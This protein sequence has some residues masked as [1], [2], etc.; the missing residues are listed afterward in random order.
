MRSWLEL[1]RESLLHNLRGVKA[2]VGQSQIMAIVK[3]NAY[4]AGA[5]EM[6]RT[7]AADGINAFGVS[8]VSEGVE[9]R[10]GGIKGNIL[11]LTYL[12]PD[13]IDALFEY[14]LTPA[15]F[16]LDTARLISE[17]ARAK[18]CRKRVWIKVDTGLGRIG[19]PFQAAPDF[20]RQ[21]AEETHLQV[22]GLFSTLTEILE[23]DLVQVRRLV[24]LR[25][26]MGLV[27]VKLS[28]A[29]SNGI[30][31]L[32][33]SYLD[34]VRPGIMLLGFEPSE[35]G[36][37][38]A[39]LVRQA[40]LQPIATWKTGVGYFKTVP[41][42]EQVGYGSRAPLA[43]D[44]Q[45]ATLM[46]GW[47]DGYPPAMSNG[48]HVLIA[49]RRC[50]IIAVSAN[51]TMVEVSG[52]VAIGDEVVLLGKQGGEEIAVAEMAKAA[53]GVYRLLAAI[54]RETPRIWN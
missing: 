46:V 34:V 48:G 41:Q 42:G 18:N 45:V 30:L 50:P 12:M 14:N 4:G 1:G 54:P 13:E 15:I 11:C 36:R 6:A 32:R 20:I 21:V 7:L 26:A 31:S 24:G 23:R 37:M 52:Q 51:S 27:N 5:V 49:G 44:T 33:E 28:I 35:R 38:D 10:K 53:G 40:D 2:L 9:L 17:R 43:Q 8:S 39:A 16:T 47:A 25:Q 19:V 29:S 22:E 3:A